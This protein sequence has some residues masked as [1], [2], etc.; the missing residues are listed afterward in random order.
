MPAPDVVAPLRPILDRI[1]VG[2]ADRE[3][4]RT[5]PSEPVVRRRDAGFGALRVPTRLGGARLSLPDL[6]EVL[7][8]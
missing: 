1:A 4:T 3:R 6:V 8:P 5:L 7:A 2:A